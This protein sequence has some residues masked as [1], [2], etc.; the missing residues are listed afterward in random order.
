MTVS[1]YPTRI[2]GDLSRYIN[3]IRL[4]FVIN[5]FT[6]ACVVVETGKNKAS[7]QSAH[8]SWS[9][10][11]KHKVC[12]IFRYLLTPKRNAQVLNSA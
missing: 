11:K 8:L 5:I 12:R 10:A 9:G 2:V 6:T 4:C 3:L 1:V 7:L